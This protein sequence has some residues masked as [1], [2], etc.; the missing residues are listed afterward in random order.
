MTGKGAKIRIAQ[1]K[2]LVA[3]RQES[4]KMFYSR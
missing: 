4:G 3:V 2:S 1:E